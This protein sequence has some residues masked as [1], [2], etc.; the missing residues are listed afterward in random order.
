MRTGYHEIDPLGWDDRYGRWLL[1]S[2]SVYIKLLETQYL[3]HFVNFLRG[4]IFDRSKSIQDVTQPLYTGNPELCHLYICCHPELGSHM[5]LSK[6]RWHESPP[7]NRYQWPIP[8]PSHKS[9]RGRTSH[10]DPHQ[11]A[12]ERDHRN[13]FPRSLPERDQRQ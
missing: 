10:P 9:N 7:C 6:P 5:G 8:S 13:A 3:V 11:P 4:H 12:W 1:V 2:K